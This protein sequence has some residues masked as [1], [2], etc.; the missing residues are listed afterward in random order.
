MDDNTDSNISGSQQDTQT[1]DFE[2]SKSE[3]TDTFTM[4]SPSSFA[5]ETE[6]T[7]NSNERGPSVRN[8]PVKDPS[9]PHQEDSFDH[10]FEA[11]S[12]QSPTGDQSYDN[13][14]PPNDGEKP[15][16]VENT[17][18][19]SDDENTSNN[20]VASNSQDSPFSRSN[21]ALDL[22]DEDQN[23]KN[24]FGSQDRNN[25]DQ[26]SD[27]E[28][29][30]Q[31]KREFSSSDQESANGQ[32]EDEVEFEHVK[33]M[34]VELL[35]KP[36]IASDDSRTIVAKLPTG[37]R[38]DPH[39]F[40][41]ESW[42]DIFE[43]ERDAFFK[44][45]KK[46]GKNQ[47]SLMDE[48][49]NHVQT[50][51]ENTARWTYINTESTNTKVPV[52][53]AYLV[54]WDTGAMTMQIGDAD[55]FVVERTSLVSNPDSQINNNNNNNNANTRPV[56]QF[57]VVHHTDED[58]LQTQDRISESWIIRSENTSQIKKLTNSTRSIG[59]NSGYF[60]SDKKRKEDSVLK[61]EDKYLLPGLSTLAETAKGTSAFQK[62]RFGSRVGTTGGTKFFI[63]DKDPEIVAKEE[64]M[65]EEAREKAA[66]KLEL[67]KRKQQ[68]R[69][70][71][72]L[73]SFKRAYKNAKLNQDS[74]NEDSSI[75]IVDRPRGIESREER[76]SK[77]NTSSRFSR[78]S[79]NQQG[80]SGG[81]SYS[82]NR[83]GNEDSDDNFIADDDEEIDEGSYDD[84]FGEDEYSDDHRERKSKSRPH[85]R[86]FDL[87]TD[88]ESA[89]DNNDSS[90]HSPKRVN[91]K[92]DQYNRGE[93]NAEK[94]KINGND[95]QSS[96]DRG[97]SRPTPKKRVLILSDEE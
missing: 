14:D 11:D 6:I 68:D 47:Q 30:R 83:Y 53:N 60:Y 38:F 96:N 80:F 26:S 34:E 63:P 48:W 44:N 36:T 71:A 72:E 95:E 17:L 85:K 28:T 8:S 33:L 54:K 52:S 31:T 5:K 37:V 90:Y 94:R 3:V 29:K 18:F 1:D 57:A 61:D 74:A 69:F 42:Y 97:Y 13:A 58:L 78:D 41:D 79:R 55:P 77:Y 51:I 12:P 91:T 64:E 32:D 59:L 81:Q 7:G 73:P 23:E 76:L 2:P 9:S 70:E 93:S 22:E 46:S 49:L 35:D 65:A 25:L 15:N 19:G 67:S 45:F 84:E 92:S 40:D 66:R 39:A 75:E 27:I 56:N 10:L 16:H 50:V 43:E 87:L 4:S 89:N 20:Y 86:N 62:K 21:D 24:K 82:S 88:E